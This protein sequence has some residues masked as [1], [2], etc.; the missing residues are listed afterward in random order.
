MKLITIAPHAT[1][2][3][4]LIAS[5][6]R[7]QAV[8]RQGTLQILEAGCGR[9]WNIDLEGLDYRLTGIDQDAEALR[10]RKEV[11]GDLDEGIVA[12]LRTVELQTGSYDVAFSAFVLEHISGAEQV[13]DRLVEALRPGGILILRVP[14]GDSVYAFLARLLPFQL[15]VWYKGWTEHDKDAGKTGH[16]P[17]PVVYD[18]IVSRQEL[19]KYPGRRGLTLVAEVG[20][21]PHIDHLRRL[22][23]VVRWGQHAFARLSQG[24]LVGTHSNLTLVYIKGHPTTASSS[25]PEPPAFS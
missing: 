20:T 16:P 1:Y 25:Q 21:N 17:Y 14:D 13:L 5:L 7:A 15:H 9:K 6:I 23:P 4:D 2:A 18:P 12:D 3:R 8:G 10:Y 22:A 24:R 19:H 11:V